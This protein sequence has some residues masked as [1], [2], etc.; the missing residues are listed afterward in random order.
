MPSDASSAPSDDKTSPPRRADYKHFLP[1]PTR[2]MDNDVYGHVNNVV[3]YSFFDTV[4]NQYLVRDGGLDIEK[5]PVIGLVV[6]T[7]CRYLKPLAF[8]DLVEAGLRVGRL[9]NSSVR[10][11]IAIFRQ[12]DSEPAA[13]G[14]FVHV[15]V[16]RATRRPVPVPES[17]RRALTRI[18]A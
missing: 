9:G 8:P 11:E 18:L 10:Y 12:G 2:W 15:Y 5:G 6:E 16:D 13:V 4:V 3:Y 7:L 17:M 14:H 1:I